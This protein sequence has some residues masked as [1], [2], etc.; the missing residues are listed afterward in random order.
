MNHAQRFQSE[1]YHNVNPDETVSPD[2]ASGGRLAHTPGGRQQI[3]C[4]LA[5]PITREQAVNGGVCNFA[6]KLS[7]TRS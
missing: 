5:E 2:F 3:R 7:R 6:A 1:I 4:P